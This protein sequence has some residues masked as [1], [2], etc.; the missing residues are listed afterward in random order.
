MIRDGAVVI[1]L[2]GVGIAAIAIGIRKFW[3]EPDRLVVIP[4]G[5]VVITLA[6]VGFAATGIR[7]RILWIDADRLV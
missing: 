2:V 7:K 1:A 6:V 4:D 5:A 3:I